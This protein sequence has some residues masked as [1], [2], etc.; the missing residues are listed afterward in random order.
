VVFFVGATVIW[1]VALNSERPSAPVASIRATSADRGSSVNA[2]PS[3]S[4]STARSSAT[5]EC[6]PV[7][8]SFRRSWLDNDAD[9]V[10]AGHFA[11][12]DLDR[13]FDII[14]CENVG[15]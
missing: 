9:G 3:R 1:R 13:L 14:Q 7:R 2:D 8:H 4:I 5:R 11:C 6:L 10:L 15:P 12:Q